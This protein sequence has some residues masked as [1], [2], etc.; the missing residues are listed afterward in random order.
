MKVAETKTVS[1]SAKSNTPFFQKGIRQGLSS[2]AENEQPFFQKKVNDFPVVQSKLNIGKPNDKYE[3]EADAVADKV[4]QRLSNKNSIQENNNVEN[5]QAKPTDFITPI[6]NFIQKKC[7]SCE[8]EEKLQKKENDDDLMKGTLQKKPIF[9][10]NATPPPP[11]DDENNVQRKC[12]ACKEEEKNVQPK[13]EGNSFTASSSIENSLLVSKGSGTPMNTAVKNEMESS[14]GMDFSSVRI[15]NNSSAIQ[16]SKDLNAQAFTHGNDIY[17]NEG[18]YDTASTTG[19]HLLA[20]ELTHTVQQGASVQ[21]AI[22]KKQ[23]THF[24]TEKIINK[25]TQQQRLDRGIEVYDL[26]DGWTTSA[27][28]ADILS[29]FRGLSR[30]DAD[31]ILNAT[32]LHASQSVMDIYKWMLADMV[33]S[34]WKAVLRIFINTNTSDVTDLIAFVVLDMLNGFTSEEDSRQIKEYLTEVSGTTLDNVLSSLET[35]A[36]STFEAMVEFLFGDLTDTDAHN[37]SLSFLSSGA[38]KAMRYSVLWYAIKIK[39]LIAG[40]T[41]IRDSHSI[42]QNFERL[43]DPESRIAVLTKLE[44]LTMAEWVETAAESFMKDMQQAD[45]NRLKEMMPIL[46]IYNI[47]RNFFEQAWDVIEAGY[48][49]LEGFIEYGVCGIVGIAVGIFDAVMSVISGVVDILFGVK[50]L[51]GWLISKA[52]GGRFCRDSEEKVNNFFTSIGEALSAPL[53]MIGR[54]W[55]ATK[56]E[57]S[58]IEGPFEECQLAIFWVRRVTNFV[59]NILLL[60]FAGYG[61]VKAAIE[62]IEAIKQISSIAELVSKIGR[63]PAAILRRVQSIPASLAAGGT[64]IISAIRNV[65]QI[66]IAVRRTIG[67]IRLAVADENF[68]INLRRAS[69]EFIESRLQVEREFWRTR[70]ERWGTTAVTEE[71][72][73]ANTERAVD[74]A[75]ASAE[76]RPGASET[77]ALEAEESALTAQKNAGNADREIRTGRTAEERSARAPGD[78]VSPETHAWERSLNAETRAMLEADP[79]LRRYWQD[80]DPAVRRALT[81]C[82]SPCIPVTVSP[83]NLVNIR[84]L[85]NRLNLSEN[86]RGLREYLHI[87]RNNNQELTNAI[88]A[89]DSITNIQQFEIFLDNRLINLIKT[90]YGVTIRRGANGLWEYPRPSDGVIVREFELGSHRGLTGRGT[91]SFFESHHGIQNAWAKNRFAGLSVYNEN[92]AETILLRTL[93]FDGGRRGAP[94]RVISELQAGRSGSISTRTYPQE[95]LALI[96]DMAAIDVPAATQAQYLINVDN[97][98][99]GLYNRLRTTISSSQLE[100]I[101][102]TWHP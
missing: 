4:V 59:V 41:S 68:F 61:A 14:F 67:I 19:N 13:S 2:S 70:R 37:L 44:E 16:M 83:E 101:F 51:I 99:G 57:A 75:T 87:Y 95:R 6:S 89:L 7:A 49:Y 34:D 50:H 86:H 100:S 69:G 40:Y 58:L 39:N 9:E 24:T 53:D 91:R 79:E 31:G 81:Y 98:F 90:E 48:D 5:I 82:S 80:M 28:S 76:T 43:P 60:I 32:A 73:I 102:G 54:M 12:E 23:I 46:P 25:L 74:S 65:D 77:Q 29:K 66:L 55:D 52:S 26:L 42:V 62:A 35:Q 18:K 30:S 71:T 15:H 92:E 85:M 3:V 84:T 36:G 33:T 27:D 64:R 45:Y 21:R 96:N 20:H 63:I 47:E 72:N 10:S 93:N 56:L 22:N 1:T 94:H 11:V 78:I 97:Y 88:R 17:F 8:Q 38:V